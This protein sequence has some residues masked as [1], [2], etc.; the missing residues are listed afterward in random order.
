MA[1]IMNASCETQTFRVFGNTF[2]M[3]PD[4]IKNFQDNIAHFI[5]VDRKDLGLVAL[6]EELDDI[7]FRDSQDGRDLLAQKK[8]EG[9]EN[10]VRKL[11]ELI[12]N[13]QVSLKQDLE[14]GNIKVDPRIFA[15]EGMVDKYKELAKYQATKEDEEQRRIDVIKDLEKKIE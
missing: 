6:P 10:R 15:S 8:K 12:Y 5:V 3:K 4:Q 1:L 11:R 9:V 7:M 2:T 14:R 13:E